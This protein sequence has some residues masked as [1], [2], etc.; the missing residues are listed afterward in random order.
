MIMVAIILALLLTQVVSCLRNKDLKNKLKI[1]EHNIT[2]LTDTITYL[3]DKNGKLLAEKTSFI[4]SIGD[5]KNLN[6][7]M[8]DNVQSLQK[9][10]QR[11][12]MA[13]ADVKMSV[14]DT[15]IQNNI[16]QYTLDSL[17]NIR[18][19]D[20]TIE[21]NSAVRIRENQVQLQNFTYNID[22]P[23]ELY[24]TKDYKMIAR[25]SNEHV[26]FSK[27]NSF[28]DPSITKYRQPKRW[29]LGLQLGVGVMPGYDL[30]KKN[31]SLSAGPYV[32]IGVNYSLIRW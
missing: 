30:V 19:A 15:I 22:L 31:F 27:L 7:E 23:L 21:A 32:G 28:I 8:Y 11:R 16:I 4:A 25:S 26:T 1:S 14:R 6:Q 24:L 29:G 20:N 13:G 12:I 18:F 2:A 9:K 5:L 10:L 3:H 17:V